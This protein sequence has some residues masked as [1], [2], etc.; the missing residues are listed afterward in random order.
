MKT[1][2]RK[3]VGQHQLQESQAYIR[4]PPRIIAMQNSENTNFKVITI[5]NQRRVL[6]A[7]STD[8]ASQSL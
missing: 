7:N 2:I 5:M 1:F 4:S 6:L 8:T 3:K